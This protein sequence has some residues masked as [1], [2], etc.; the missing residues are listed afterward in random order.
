MSTCVSPER[1]GGPW[2]EVSGTIHLAPPERGTLA[3]PGPGVG[4]TCVPWESRLGGQAPCQASP[5][6]FLINTQLPGNACRGARFAGSGQC[7]VRAWGGCLCPGRL[8][9]VCM[10][11][12]CHHG[13]CVPGVSWVLDE[14]ETTASPAEP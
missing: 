9:H 1:P 3:D 5:N 10:C 2:G 13:Q 11:H 6:F 7:R 4:C 14:N 8:A 12:V